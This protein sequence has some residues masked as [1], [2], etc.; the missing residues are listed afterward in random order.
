MEDLRKMTKVQTSAGG[1]NGPVRGAP[2]P[3]KA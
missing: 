2:S 1:G 3:T